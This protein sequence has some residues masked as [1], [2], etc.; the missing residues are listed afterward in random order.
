MLSSLKNIVWFV[1]FREQLD[2]ADN[3]RDPVKY[4]QLIQQVI[5]YMTKGI[6][7]TPL[8]MTIVKVD[9]HNGLLA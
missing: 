8:F 9:F 1:M 7:M 6:D 5:F 2:N 4:K 3:Q